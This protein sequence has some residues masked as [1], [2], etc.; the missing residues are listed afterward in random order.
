LIRVPYI[1]LTNYNGEYTC[2][3]W[4]GT[5]GG[6]LVLNAQTIN[7]LDDIEISGTGFRRGEYTS[8]NYTNCTE[9]NFNY[10]SSS[11]IAGE[12]GESITSVSQ[13][14]SKGKGSPAAGGGGGVSNNSGGAGGGNGGSGGYGG[15]QTDSCANAPFD[16]RGIGGRSLTNSTSIDKIFMGSG[17]GAG[18]AAGLS[19]GSYTDGNG[20]GIAII[21]ANTFRSNGLKIF[22]NGS[23][24]RICNTAFCNDGMSGGGAG[25]TVLFYVNQVIDNV[26]VE[27][28]G[29]NGANMTGS[30]LQG[31]KA[32]PGGG[33]G[34]G[35][36]F[37][38]QSAM[39]GNFTH[40]AT[41]GNSGVI[42]ADANNPSGA[43]AGTNGVTL[44][45][46]K[47]PFDTDL[48][49]PNID[50]VR[51]ADSII[52]CNSF[53]F[54]GMGFTNTN[55]IVSWLWNF[56]DGNTSITQNV[57]HTYIA[58]KIYTVKLIATDL[59]G[60][61]DSITTLVNS[62]IVAVDAGVNKN[63]CSNTPV[64]VTLN[65]IGAGTYAWSPALYL[66]DST[67]Q[68]PVANLTSSTTFYL[69]LT[70]NGCTV[71]D[72]V[73]II[74]SPAPVIKA[75][76]SNDVNCAL[77]YAKLKAVGASQ[78]AWYPAATLNNSTIANPIANP[79]ATITY[80]VN[81]TNDNICF[82]KDSITVIANFLSRTIELPNS[83]TPNGDGIN[84]CFGIKYYR[85]VQNLVFTIFNRYGNKVF[86][87]SNA[88]ECWDG[89]YLGKP[90]VQGSYIYYLSATTLCGDIIRKGSILLIR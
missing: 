34:A 48:F 57:N 77:P 32:G 46:L 8:S 31:G 60:C 6:V 85:D 30:I 61:R 58:E 65:G 70:N 71:S 56:G 54:K 37:F 17:G 25:G 20:G 16:N 63:V 12:K 24:G 83:F 79:A 74:I 27:T 10:P 29:G 47:N 41:G 13:N 69:T 89:N 11:G 87:T 81:G 75:S 50:S 5:T 49:K 26:T 23:D 21:I 84:D 33:G 42:T 9:N 78:Y 52:T 38:N 28:K 3:P 76:K 4:N 40:T 82:G 90:S 66:N 7:L 53:N 59:N 18:H 88:A 2:L 73:K 39:P 55:P 86:E 62:R 35:V 1:K 44:F 67:L 43:T 64:A 22:A 68:N 36:F 51:I 14:I 72:S 19:T 80:F 15:Y 45:D